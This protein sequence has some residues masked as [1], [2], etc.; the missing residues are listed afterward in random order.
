MAPFKV[1]IVGGGPA[2]LITGHCL[3]KAAID[4]DILESRDKHDLNA[5]ASNALW[6]QSVRV[7]DQLGLLEEATKLHSPVDYRQSL[8]PEG[9]P[10]YKSDVFKQTR[11]QHGHSFMLFHRAELL[12]LL[13]RRLPDRASRV[14]NNKKV[15]SIETHEHGV[16]VV[17]ADGSSFQG[18]MVIGAD[19]ANSTVR[20]LM[21]EKSTQKPKKEPMETTYVGLYGSCP[22]LPTFEAGTF[23]ETHGPK[24][25]LQLGVGHTR[26]Y[27]VIYHR[28][29]KP[30]TGRHRF[31]VEEKTALAAEYADRYITPDHRFKD[32]WDI[33]L[34]SHMAHIEE[35]L[36]EKW[37][38]GRIV[39]V[40]DNVH[41]MM[42]NA[43]FGFNSAVISAAALTNGLRRLVLDK[44]DSAGIRT[45][46][47]TQVFATYEKIRKPDA[48]KFV[49]VS[50]AY[51]RAVA[52]DNFVFRFVDRYI[53]P[54]IRMDIILLKGLMSPLVR[55]G[56][57]LDFLEEK[58]FKEGNVKWKNPKQ[59]LAQV[60]TSGGGGAKT[61]DDQSA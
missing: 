29:D 54:Y 21:E 51:A 46:E 56:L 45:D 2:G 30:T 28:L 26:G 11:A 13:D 57:V 42:P 12:D 43:G 25:S 59:T 61:A 7:F 3:A 18:S 41:K 53:G 24:F 47:L 40:G 5:G 19:G 49:D 4:F 15:T 36:V 14:H 10:F 39:L 31:S 55:Q 52:W 32:I 38:G 37:Y 22:L 58:D 8:T 48:R 20:R 60:E 9:T 27:F 35:G 16:K 50:A 23:Y 17:C 44:S 6:P 1:I 34:W 33:A